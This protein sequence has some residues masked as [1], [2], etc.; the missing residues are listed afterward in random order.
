MTRKTELYL[1]STYTLSLGGLQ[2]SVCQSSP[3][4]VY[5]WRLRRPSLQTF[6]RGE[7][8]VGQEELAGPR[9]VHLVSQ[10]QPVSPEPFVVLQHK[11][12][13]GVN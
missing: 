9:M 7:L 11:Q 2:N 4:G 6:L 3:K 10:L 1:S 12:M 8:F 13:G 5:I